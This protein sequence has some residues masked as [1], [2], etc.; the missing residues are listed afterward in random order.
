[1]F[2]FSVWLKGQDT[3]TEQPICKIVTDENG[4]AITPDL[5][6]GEYVIKETN[7]KRIV[8]LLLVKIL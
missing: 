3:D 2:E 6:Y 5:R 4:E 8:C 1:M 7:T